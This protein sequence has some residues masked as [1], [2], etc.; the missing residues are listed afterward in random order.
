MF[1][2]KHYAVRANRGISPIWQIPVQK[3]W[4]SLTK[5]L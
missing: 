4:P 5:G 2:A 1:F 3:L